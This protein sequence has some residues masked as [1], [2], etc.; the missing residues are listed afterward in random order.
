MISRRFLSSLGK[1]GLWL[2]LAGSGFAQEEKESRHWAFQ[3]V[4]RPTVPNVSDPGWVQTPIDAFILSRLQKVGLKP[5]PAIDRRTLLRRAYLD[6]IGLPPTPEEQIRFLNDPSPTAFERVVDDLLSRPQYGE[7]WGRHWL[8]AVRYAESNGYERDGAKPSAWRYRDYVIDSL[9]ADKPY[10][11]W[12]P[13]TM[14]RRILKWI[15]TINWMTSWA[16]RPPLSWVSRCA[17]PA[18]M[19]TSSSHSRK[20]IT[21]ACWRYLNRSSARKTIAMNGIGSSVLRKS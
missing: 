20:M 4:K 14:S 3:P 13:G 15:A 12:A 7:R 5:A 10:D 6:L 2:A 19:T 11:R 8:D 1:A 21:I 9:N 17:A 18:A 16:P